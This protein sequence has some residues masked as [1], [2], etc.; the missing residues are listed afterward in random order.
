MSEPYDPRAPFDPQPCQVEGCSADAVIRKWA[1]G[2][3][4]FYVCEDHGEVDP[5][6]PEPV[7]GDE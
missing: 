7:T 3:A 6:P 5:T 1:M 4:P 2:S